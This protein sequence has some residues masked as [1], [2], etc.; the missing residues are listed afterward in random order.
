MRRA[1]PVTVADA[2]QPP[3]AK[4]VPRKLVAHGAERI[5]DYFW[6]NEREAPDVRAYLDAENAYVEHCLA[7][8]RQLRSRLLSEMRARIPGNE[9]TA[10][11]RIDDWLYYLRYEAGKEYA[12]YC[13]KRASLE[14]DEERL[15]DVND[16]AAGKAYF[17][18]SGF[19]VSPNHRL[20]AFAVDEQGRRIYTLQ[21]KDL[22]SGR[23]LPEC[24]PSV[25]GNHEWANDSRTIFYA[26]LD[27]GTL[28]SDSV[29][30]RTLGDGSSRLVYAE[31]DET[32]S[33]E[34][35]KS[36]SERWLFISA[37]STVSTEYRCIPADE[38]NR[39]P[40][41][42]EPRRRDHEYHV[43][44]GGDRFYILTNWQARNFRVMQTAPERTA[45]SHWLEVVPHREDVLLEGIE[46]FARHLVLE[47]TRDG[48]DRIRIMDRQTGA[49]RCVDFEEPAFTAYTEDNY[50]YDSEWLRYGYESLTTPES[51]Y[52][53][54]LG[55]GERRLVKRREVPGNFDPAAYQ[56]ERMLVR[57]RDGKRIPISLVYRRG[58][59]RN[60]RNPMLLYAYGAYGIST[61]P[62]FD[63]RR[64]SLLDRG[65]IYAIAHV[66]GGA[67]MGRAWYDDGKLRHKRNSFT[68][69]IDC[70]EAL[71]ELELTSP[72]HLYACGGSAGGLL[73]AAVMNMRPDL[74]H[75]G[76]AAVPFVDLVTTM[77]DER[78]PLTTG[79]YD[80]WGDPNDASDY[81]CMISYSP[82]DNVVEQD[83][84]HLLVTAGLHDSQVQY[85]EP[86]KWVAKLRARKTDA[87]LLLLRTNMDAGHG[88]ASGRFR[89]LEETTVHYAFLL[90]LEGIER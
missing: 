75:G 10:P 19:A 65:F 33:V 60:G 56:A 89:R 49:A 80:E 46:V 78:I 22:A 17:Q 23:M 15:L 6:L 9:T 73:V 18:V 71:I 90:S 43:E 70:S 82:Y 64:L 68:D 69:Y 72:A 31:N 21:F 41:L 74:Y 85:W 36:K 1:P 45:R 14:G 66:R 13:R 52:D 20:A 37:E 86:A 77:L 48:L 44:D 67:E 8:T 88:G 16:L 12:I 57:A 38:P 25:T 62:G 29:H 54:H 2:P 87:N 11:V 40:K 30:R 34:V 28:R 50:E 63:T 84:P 53:H 61:E 7:R 55:T 79:E 3:R 5:D 51:A 47:E 4:R 32:F 81:A 58:L 42:F 24:I 76:I 83:Y 59:R 27:P 39:A 35:S 26:A